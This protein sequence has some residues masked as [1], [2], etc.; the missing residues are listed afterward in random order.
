MRHWRAYCTDVASKI[1]K[2]GPW[3]RPF[4]RGINDD[5]IGIR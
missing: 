5:D 4:F 2:M 3:A 1:P